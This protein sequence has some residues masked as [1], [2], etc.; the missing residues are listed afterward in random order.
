MIFLIIIVSYLTSAISAQSFLNVN[1]IHE[2]VK[3][4]DLK[5]ERNNMSYFDHVERPRVL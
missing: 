2:I 1:E 4:I 5:E 3:N